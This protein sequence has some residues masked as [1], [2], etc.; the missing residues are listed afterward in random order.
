MVVESGIFNIFES[1][2]IECAVAMVAM[3]EQEGIYFRTCLFF[4]EKTDLFLH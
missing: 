3:D 1:R 2:T 4:Q